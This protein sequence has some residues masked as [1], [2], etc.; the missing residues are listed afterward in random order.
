MDKTSK[1]DFTD[2][3]ISSAVAEGRL[4][5]MEIEFSRACNYN[6]PYCYVPGTDALQ[7]ELTPDEIRSVLCQASGLGAKKIIILGGEPLLYLHLF[8]MIEHISSLGMTSEVFTNGSLITPENAKRLFHAGVR[9]SVKLNSLDPGIHD[10]LTGEKDSMATALRAIAILK[11][12]GYGKNEEGML[13]ASSIISSRNIGGIAS[14][15][16][17]LREEHITPYFEIITPQGRVMDNRHLM[18][19]GHQLLK[20]FSDISAIDA[21][22]GHR[23]EPQPPLVG[24]KCFRHTYSCLVNSVGDVMPC[25]GLTVV[26]GNIRSKPLKG[27]LA[28]SGIISRLKNFRKYIK[29]PCADCSKAEHCYGCRG[30]AY[31]VTGDYLAADPTCWFNADKP[32]QIRILPVDAA[33]FIP[34]Q[35]P[36]SMID[37][38]VKIGDNSGDCD[39]LVAPDNIFLDETGILSCSAL[40]E[41]ASQAA[42]AINSFLNDGRVM[43]GMLVG[44]RSFRF[45][46]EV[47]SGDLMNISID[48]VAE[49][50][51]YHIII[52]SIS[53]AGRKICEGEL[54]I[55]VLDN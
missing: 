8:E 33:P 48:K 35:P 18:V 31:Q 10:E 9:I 40:I 53:V 17:W 46:G 22:F 41:A 32:D 26:I 39:S 23:W 12:A 36:I 51:R 24:R 30:A 52:A 37:R 28:E 14:L 3:E 25:V 5:S 49:F 29:K 50:D 19:D 6:C 54:K 34:H 38:I 1:F 45:F 7:D 21:D 20:V 55:C 44:A 2:A 15:W 27:I 43:P 13:A 11:D 42:A 4:L 16:R 47:R